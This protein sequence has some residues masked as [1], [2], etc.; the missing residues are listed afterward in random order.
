MRKGLDR[1]LMR[2]S[3]AGQFQGNPQRQLGGGGG[4]E[5]RSWDPQLKLL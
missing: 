5:L 4:E 2:L 1:G 3:V